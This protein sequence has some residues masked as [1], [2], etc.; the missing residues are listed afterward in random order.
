MYDALASVEKK[1]EKGCWKM[2]DKR[3]QIWKIALAVAAF[4]LLWFVGVM[5]VRAES[6][7][8]D[9]QGSITVNLDDIGT[10]RGNVGLECYQV[11]MPAQDN[12]LTW[13]SLPGFEQ[14]GIDW[15]R[16]SKSEDYAAAAERLQ[17]YVPGSGASPLAGKTNALGVLE[18]KDLDQGVYL[19]LQTDQAAYGE[20]SPFLVGIPFMD[21]GDAWIYDVE[22]ETKGEKLA[23]ATPTATPTGRITPVTKRPVTS[24]SRKNSVKTGDEAPVVY[25]V[26]L[27]VM[28]MAAAGT[29]LTVRRKR[30]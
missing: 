6:Y 3:N 11:A 9:R 24:T 14:A 28:A 12:I 1:E 5:A 15:E 8:P 13:V 17:G 20:I 19:I 29:V 30:D 27:G 18:F 23:T 22:T 2:R 16:L 4:F 21:G 7:D 25:L 26:L 10:N